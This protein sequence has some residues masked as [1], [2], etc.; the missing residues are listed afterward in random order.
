MLFIMRFITTIKRKYLLQDYVT[1]IV[2]IIH[3]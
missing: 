1:E 3:Y 2:N